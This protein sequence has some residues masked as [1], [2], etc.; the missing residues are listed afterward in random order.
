MLA[1]SSGVSVAASS[2]HQW[3]SVSREQVTVEPAVCAL[4]C[5]ILN[6][7]EDVLTHPGHLLHSR[8]NT[9]QAAARERAQVPTGKRRPVQ[10]CRHFGT[11]D[12][13]QGLPTAELRARTSPR[14]S[15]RQRAWSRWT[16][17]EMGFSP[18]LC[19]T[20]CA[21][22]GDQVTASVTVR[23]HHYSNAACV[24]VHTG[25]CMSTGVPHR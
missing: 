11:G 9:S 25:V 22:P 5:R 18:A 24:T 3:V 8:S 13:G 20:T 17:L 2:P 16:T 21:S 7:S 23:M 4:A 1:R 15:P 12:R 6:T 10:S 14:P 19:A